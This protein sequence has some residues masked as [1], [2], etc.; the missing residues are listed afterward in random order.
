MTDKWS[1]FGAALWDESVPIAGTPAEAYL[2]GRGISLLPSPEVLRFHPAAQHPKLKRELPSLIARVTGG[3]EPSHNFT[4]LSADGAGKAEIE[5]AEQRRT[6]GSSKGGAVRLAEPIDGKPLIVGEGIETTATAM[7]ATGLPGWASLGTSGLGNIEWPGDVREV[8]LLAENDENGANQRALDKACPVLAEQGLKVRVAAPPAGFKDFNDLAG[9]TKAGREP[10]G[11]MIAKTIIEAAPEWR[12]KRGK[13]ANPTARKQASQASFLVDL[14]ASRCD[15][16]CDPSGEAYASFVAA[17]DTGAHRETHRIRSKGFNM[18]L[19]SLFYA[20]RDAAPSSEAMAS[21]VKTMMAKAHFDG[22]RRDV[23]LR[24][25]PLEGMIYLDMCDP[26]WRAIEIDV[27]GF[28]IVDDPPLHFRREAGML[29]LPAPSKIDPKKGIERL[30]EVLRLRDKRD[31][32]IIAAWLLA[33]LAGR[34]PYAVLS[35]LGEPGATKTSA[36]YAVRSIIDPNASPLRTKPKDPHDVFVAA[37]HSLVVGYNNL[38]GLPD[39]L[40]DTICV[41][42]EGSGESRRE[43]FTDADES[44]IVACAPFLL[45]GIENVVKR[46]DLAQRT[47][48][49]HLAS[50]PDGE[51]L[52][53]QTFKARFNRA[54]ADLLGALCAAASAGLRNEK[55]L[56]LDSLPRLAT[57]FHWASACER[58]LW[59][60]GEFRRAFAANAKDATEDVIEGE[61]AASVFR[62][63][64]A[65]RGNWTGTATQL[66]ADL[67]AF[68]RRPVREAEAAHAQ[69]VK[70]KDDAAKEKTAAALREARETAR[71]VLGDGWPKAPNALTGKL[72]R[73]SP[74]LRNA[75]VRIDWPT[76]HGEKKIIKI[77]TTTPKSRRQKSSPS[78]S[79]TNQ[80]NDVKGLVKKSKDDCGR[81]EDDLA[82]FEDDPGGD[83]P[84]QGGTIAGRSPSERSSSVT[85]LN[86]MGDLAATAK[87]DDGDDLSPAISDAN[88]SIV[89]R[90][91]S[92]FD[93]FGF[94]IVLASDGSLAIQDL[95]G[96]GRRHPR[97]LPPQLLADFSEHADAIGRWLEEGGTL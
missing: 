55:S 89:A 2:R 79:P 50:V 12:P 16:F 44:L 61:Q 76:R 7:E 71:D 67:V 21:A 69:A 95:C 46:G 96:E 25:A 92:D 28:R 11:L 15:L 90:I 5:K 23:Y 27:D 70:D 18:W 8:I 39:W 31:F 47:L 45:T 35:F 73:A 91:I 43:L 54:H 57:F 77:V 93:K 4:W 65:E 33:A 3:V 64:M 41:V 48:Y 30:R 59:R 19:R 56:K 20:E 88:G 40:S 94:R 51:R 84:A 78:S 29:A 42:S 82:R 24:T 60:R 49:V 68:V 80:A 83:G 85:T 58:A 53:E 17:P 66:L 36:A 52:T 14:A 32:V 81:L 62:R 13:G 75:G 86:S 1:K 74:A 9:P 10:S 87:Q 38:S 22:D 34:S 63:F 6:L 26:L 37:T 97:A 72:K